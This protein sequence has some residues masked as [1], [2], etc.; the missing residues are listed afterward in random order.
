MISG[1]I[2]KP[3]LLSFKKQCALTT[4][5][6]LNCYLNFKISFS[7]FTKKKKKKN[8]HNFN[9]DCSESVAQFRENWCLSNTELSNPRTHKFLHLF[10][11]LISV[12][13][14]YNY[15]CKVLAHIYFNLTLSILFFYAI[16]FGIVFLKFLFQLFAM[17]TYKCFLFLN[18]NCMFL[19]LA[20][21]SFW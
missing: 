6:L 19:D 11:S 12:S 16:L 5:C 18:I 2:H 13:R 14:V 20:K 21:F 10:R 7:M 1:S 9:W 8:Y 17:S 15:Q 3:T 4:L